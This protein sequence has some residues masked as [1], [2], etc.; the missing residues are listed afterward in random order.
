M[1]E[2]HLQ[3]IGLPCVLVITH[4]VSDCLR[5]AIQSLL[6]VEKNRSGSRNRRPRGQD[7]FFLRP[8]GCSK[9][10]GFIQELEIRSSFGIPADDV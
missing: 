3:G 8:P 7:K 1:G 2:V 9:V 5:L 6:R 10:F 4:S